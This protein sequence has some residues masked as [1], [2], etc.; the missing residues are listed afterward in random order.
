[1][2]LIRTIQWKALL[3]L[4]VFAANFMVVCHCSARAEGHTCCEKKEARQPC[5]DGNGCSGMHAVKFNL[6]E[7]KASPHIGLDPLYAVVVVYTYDRRMEVAAG[8]Q[9]TFADKWPD[10]SPPDLQSL[11]QCFRI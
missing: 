8:I 11:Y 3:M 4:T 2:L 10:C 1:M 5:K 7:K 6:L 9:Q